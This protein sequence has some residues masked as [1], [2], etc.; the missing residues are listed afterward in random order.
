MENGSSYWPTN[1]LESNISK[2]RQPRR[3]HISSIPTARH[4][5]PQQRTLTAFP[6]LLMTVH[7][8]AG[9]SS[10]YNQYNQDGGYEP[11]G[12]AVGLRMTN[13]YLDHFS[14]TTAAMI[15]MGCI[16]CIIIVLI[17]ALFLVAFLPR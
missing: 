2:T 16:L 13:T 14:C 3:T 15:A 9:T 10:V 1:P 6:S 12:V 8:A 5:G 17:V 7:D 11:A 4:S